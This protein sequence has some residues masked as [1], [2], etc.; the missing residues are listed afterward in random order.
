MLII[1]T[2]ESNLHPEWQHF[3]LDILFELSKLGF[4]VV[5][6]THSLDIISRKQRRFRTTLC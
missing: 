4:M 3:M 1:D 2:P 6:T 5:M